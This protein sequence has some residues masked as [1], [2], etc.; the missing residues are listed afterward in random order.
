MEKMFLR[1]ADVTPG[2]V[3]I[4]FDGLY[5]YEGEPAPKVTVALGLLRDGADSKL[6]DVPVA[7]IVGEQG[8]AEPRGETEYDSSLVSYYQA[9]QKDEVRFDPPQFIP[10]NLERFIDGLDEDLPYGM[11]GEFEVVPN[12]KKD[13]SEQ[14]KDRVY[15][16]AIPRIKDRGYA[17]AELAKGIEKEPENKRP[18]LEPLFVAEIVGMIDAVRDLYAE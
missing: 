11:H 12:A 16:R 9:V 13:W 4:R 10:E 5:E 7:N 14:L 2:E 6:E 8:Y 17:N 1:G 15:R 3:P 18:A